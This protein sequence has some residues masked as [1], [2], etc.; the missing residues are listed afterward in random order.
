MHAGKVLA[1]G[2]PEELVRASGTKT[3]EEAFIAQLER[4]AAIEPSAGPGVAATEVSKPSSER[5]TYFSTRRFWAYARREAMEILRDPVRLAFALLGPMLLMVVFGFGISFDVEDLSYATLDQD[6][7]PESRAYLEHFASSRYFKAQPELA[8]YRDLERRMRGGDLDVALVVPPEFGRRV[9]ANQPVVELGVWLD[10]AVP[11]RAETARGYVESVHQTYLN[12]LARRDSGRPLAAAQVDVQT[13]FRYNQDF[14]SVYAV[15]PGVI[16]VMLGLIPGIMTA[17]GVVREKERGSIINLYATPVTGIEFLVGKQLPYIAIAFASYL[18]L[19][20][21]ALALFD[22]PLK[23]SFAA[24]SIGAALYVTAT[25]GFGLLV[26]SFMKTQVA[27]LFGTAVLT[28]IPVIQFSGMFTPVS[29]L[30]GG[31]RIMGLIFP[32]TYFMQISLGTFTKA[33]QFSDLA[34]H[35]WALAAIVAV[36]VALSLALLRTQER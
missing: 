16:M 6:R 19:L 9:K 33:L 10:G 28:I 15:V 5:P 3:L 25:T 13:R 35:F 14:G 21:L 18:S 22:V 30:S 24:L 2:T 8:D 7:T 29:S 31:P 20:A 27:A 4:V 34:S 12:D 23:G 17:I 36:Y 1:Q 11:F 32:S 26:S